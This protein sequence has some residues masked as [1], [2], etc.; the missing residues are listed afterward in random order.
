MPLCINNKLTA[1]KN[2]GTL[3]V[4]INQTLDKGRRYIGHYY[5]FQKNIMKHTL[6]LVLLFFNTFVN[7]QENSSIDFKTDLSWQQ[8]L[9]KAKSD[10]KLVF[11]DIYTDWCVP[12]KRMEKEV[13]SLKNVSDTFNG[14]FINYRINAEKGEGIDVAKRYG[15]GG[16]PYFT[17]VDGNGTLYYSVMG[18]RDERQL[19]QDAAIAFK[20]LNDAKPYG[21]WTSEYDA[22]KND[23][24]WLKD[25]IQKRNML[26][27]D[28]TQ[29]LE[30]FYA[31]LK[32]SMY[33]KAENI[34]LVTNSSGIKLNGKLFK[35]LTS[36]F[37]TIPPREDSLYR[38]QEQLVSIFDNAINKVAVK[39]IEEKNEISL[40]K[41]VLPAHA[42]Y[43]E[44]V[45]FMPW[46]NKQQT[47]WK[48]I[49]Y[50]HTNNLKKGMPVAIEYINKYYKN[51]S[52]SEIQKRDSIIYE[53]T[54][55]IYK[56]KHLDSQ[57]MKNMMPMI[58][59]YFKRFV[60]NNH[61]EKLLGASYLVY[62]NKATPK[63]LNMALSWTKRAVQIQE[64]SATL[65]L[66][67][68]ILY[69][70]NRR[71]ESIVAMESAVDYADNPGDRNRLTLLLKSMKENKKI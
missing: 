57:Q 34:Q 55:K 26:R 1:F 66:M 16:Y 15:V 50:Q 13:F 35:L 51:L 5:Q 68:K 10:N 65:E 70:I 19:L 45:R 67:S 64:N 8:V 29:L 3:M 9:Q 47:N 20:E 21:V 2:T 22:N 60:T 48:F 7:G 25:Y 71:Q 40:L 30:D 63:E 61:V 18:Y 11:V 56:S 53:S 38:L 44:K 6:T 31:L 58:E 23:V 36:N 49:F 39:A 59:Q 43:P 37:S 54:L 33:V 46:Y 62:N 28:N 14:K 52:V 12:C 24:S 42:A 41:E 17:F 27:M 69:R 32:P 4:I